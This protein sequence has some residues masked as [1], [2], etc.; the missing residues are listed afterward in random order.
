MGSNEGSYENGTSSS[1]ENPEFIFNTCGENIVGL[2]VT[3][4]LGCDSTYY[5][6]VFV[7]GSPNAD[8]N[9]NNFE[10]VG[11]PTCITDLSTAN[12]NPNCYLGQLDLWQWIIKDENDTI[13]YSNTSSISNNFCDTLIPICNPSIISSDYEIKLIITDQKGC[14]D[15]S[16]QVNTIF[17]NPQANFDNSGVCFDSI[18][19]GIKNFINLSSPQNGVSF[20]W[21]FGDGD[22][23]TTINP[24]HTYN[25]TGSYNVTLIL[26]GNNCNDTIVKTVGVFDEYLVNLTADTI[27]CY[28]QN[29]GFINTIPIGGFSPYNYLWNGP[30]S[31]SSS[32]QNINNLYTGLYSVVVTDNNG[33]ITNDTLIATIN[34]SNTGT[35][36]VT[37][38]DSY[39]WN[40]QT[41]TTT[42]NYN[43]T[44]TNTAGC[45]SLHTLNVI[46]RESFDD[47]SY[48]TTCDSIIWDGITYSLTGMYTNIYTATNGCDSIITINLNI[49]SSDSVNSSVSACESYQ[50]NISTYKI[51]GNYNQTF[52]NS[53][54]M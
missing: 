36:S 14:I 17:C 37:A 26:L 34:Y 49:V 19:G 41:I 43:Q 4:S 3:D 25:D 23:S 51:S 10:C 28:S 20:I 12:Q 7:Y 22:S 53:S 40:A 31:Y 13:V 8:F 44:F 9:F 33:C 6:S 39:V 24:T 48:I 16:V 30:N 21:Y 5:S 35:T 18:N 1:S 27:L 52:I 32:S 46:I 42:G 11:N 2:T 50:W 47:T 45:D 54:W 38:C 29:T 15:S